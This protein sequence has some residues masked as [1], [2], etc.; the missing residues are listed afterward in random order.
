MRLI[1]ASAFPPAAARRCS[2]PMH[3]GGRRD[4]YLSRRYP[5]HAVDRHLE[6]R[7][8]T[9]RSTPSRT[10]GHP[11]RKALETKTVLARCK[12]SPIDE[13]RQIRRAGFTGC[14]PRSSSPPCRRFCVNN[15]EDR[16]VYKDDEELEPH[17]ATVPAGADLAVH[18]EGLA[19]GTPR[20]ELRQPTE[21]AP[22]ANDRRR[23]P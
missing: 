23:G 6:R 1:A 18:E 4:A 12:S 19:A 10:P 13:R 20:R 5:V 2:V 21:N 16:N 17:F 8:A 14:A 15:I 22:A 9:R 7:L 3:W 11:Y